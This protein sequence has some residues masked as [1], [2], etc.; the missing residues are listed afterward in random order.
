MGTGS[1]LAAA[2]ASLLALSASAVSEGEL[3]ST[4]T[5]IAQRVIEQSRVTQGDPDAVVQQMDRWGEAVATG[6][7]FRVEWEGRP[8]GDDRWHVMVR[9]S[10]VRLSMPVVLAAQFARRTP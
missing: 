7:L 2:S 5:F 9:V 3:Q 6:G 8:V 10:T 1:V 4:A